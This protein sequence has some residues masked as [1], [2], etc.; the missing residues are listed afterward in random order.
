MKT[1]CTSDIHSI[2]SA[3]Q[4]L[5]TFRQ[6]RNRLFGTESECQQNI[7]ANAEGG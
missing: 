5:A 1:L 4:I 7:V 3:V 2:S 6:I